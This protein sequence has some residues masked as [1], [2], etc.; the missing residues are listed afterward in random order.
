M[1]ILIRRVGINRRSLNRGAHRDSGTTTAQDFSL[2][3]ACVAVAVGQPLEGSGGWQRVRSLARNQYRC[4]LASLRRSL[5][6]HAKSCRHR[7]P[8]HEFFSLSSPTVAATASLIGFCRR[9]VPFT[10]SRFSTL[11]PRVPNRRSL[12]CNEGDTLVRS[13]AS[14]NFYELSM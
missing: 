10:S 4:R 7:L 2:D 3:A 5:A 8:R 1:K 12:S 9:V 11:F 14:F 13:S 6:T